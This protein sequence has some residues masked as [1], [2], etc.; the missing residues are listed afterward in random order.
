MK[1]R[2]GEC[3][4]KISNP[5]RV[6]KVYKHRFSENT[7]LARGRTLTH[8]HSETD[9]ILFSFISDKD[10]RTDSRIG[11]KKKK[12]SAALPG[13][14]PRVLRILVARPWVRFPAGLRCVVFFR[15]IR[16]SVLLSLSEMKEKRI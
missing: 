9:Q 13:I 4:G 10:R 14:E 15:L 5:Y 1:D 7:E 2:H 16:L 11:R 8:Q 3:L 12:N 6:W